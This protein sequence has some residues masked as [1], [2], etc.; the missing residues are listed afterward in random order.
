MIEDSAKR[1]IDREAEGTSLVFDI[2]CK[3]KSRY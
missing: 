1:I 3:F 2:L